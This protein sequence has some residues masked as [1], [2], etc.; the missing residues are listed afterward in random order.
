MS[1]PAGGWAS[2]HNS[3]DRRAVW[4]GGGD[5]DDPANYEPEPRDDGLYDPPEEDPP[6]YDPARDGPW[7]DDENIVSAAEYRQH[8]AEDEP[9][10]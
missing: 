10:F 7:E 8:Y 2:I 6:E 9:P 5:P 4:E 1:T 3:P